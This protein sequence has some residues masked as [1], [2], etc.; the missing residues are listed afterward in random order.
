MHA[1]GLER[2]SSN[3]QR[4]AMHSCLP[5]TNSLPSMTFARSTVDR[6]PFPQSLSVAAAERSA[7]VWALDASHANDTTGKCFSAV[8][9]ILDRP[10]SY[11]P[12][13][14]NEQ[15][16]RTATGT[17][18]MQPDLSVPIRSRAELALRRRA[19]W[20]DAGERAACELLGRWNADFQGWIDDEQAHSRQG[21]TAVSSADGAVRGP[22]RPTGA[23]AAP[24]MG[25]GAAADV[26]SLGSRAS[27]QAPAQ[28]EDG[29]YLG[30]RFGRAR[31]ASRR[32]S[33]PRAV[34]APRARDDSTVAAAR[35]AASVSH[36]SG[37][38]FGQ[39]L[40][41]ADRHAEPVVQAVPG[42]EGCVLI[43]RGSS[44]A[45]G[46]GPSHEACT[47]A[48]AEAAAAVV[49]AAS[50]PSDAPAAGP[51]RSPNE[52]GR[53]LARPPPTFPTAGPP[54]CDSKVPTRAELPFH[55]I[56]APARS[57][58]LASNGG[59]YSFCATQLDAVSE[60][61]AGG[62]PMLPA[63][64][65]AAAEARKLRPLPSTPPTA[66]RRHAAGRGGGGE[67]RGGGGEGRGGGGEGRGGCGRCDGLATG[68]V[69][70]GIVSARP[71]RR[72]WYKTV[73]VVMSKRGGRE[74]HRFVDI[75][76]GVSEFHFGRTTTRYD[77]S[78]LVGPSVPAH[79][80]EVSESI[81]AALMSSYPLDARYLHAPRALLEVLVGGQPMMVDGRV[82]FVQITPTRLL[83]DPER[84]ALLHRELFGDAYYLPAPPDLSAM[85][86][87]DAPRVL[88]PSSS[89]PQPPPPPVPRQTVPCGTSNSSSCCDAP[90]D[91]VTV[92]VAGTAAAAGAVGAVGAMDAT[93]A[94]GAVGARA[95]VD[96]VDM[97]A[98][99][100]ES[101]GGGVIVMA[102]GTGQSAAP[103]SPIAHVEEMAREA[104]WASDAEEAYEVEIRRF[105]DALAQVA[106]AHEMLREREVA[107]LQLSSS[108]AN[109]GSLPDDAD[110]TPSPS[111]C[112]AMGVRGLVACAAAPA[113]S[114]G[115][116]GAAAPI[117][118]TVVETSSA[119]SEI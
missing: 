18:A 34:S 10:R 31:A 76:N 35:P 13:Q 59:A 48:P 108:S 16:L 66:A 96:A 37:L 2:G 93:D 99:A 98:E 87:P 116:H 40:R 57:G 5:M 12:T 63:A 8:S 114:D 33:P 62:R 30:S 20:A 78:L 36:P 83:A 86:R 1:Q 27:A 9:S 111:A 29:A 72:R 101:A 117:A 81:Q 4:H 65:A 24:S 118:R 60:L 92:V 100:A 84:F 113:T 94:P 70:A 71:R 58:P 90:T 107:Q 109:M 43:D 23:P 42:F 28:G 119:D 80:F 41:H 104:A 56:A 88:P 11:I 50:A 6:A 15:P 106:R 85:L 17:G 79:G 47:A 21:G 52:A 49:S 51:P 26:T 95:D 69:G 102:T 3:L 77:G 19:V 32:N 74:S 44:L 38:L 53:C 55:H 25:G 89:P 46:G 68:R 64:V 97:I 82:F 75:V 103:R 110:S 112:K 67:G 45:R 61:A 73:A 91:P 22:P 39:V 54:G 115:S 14:A 105:N 7:G